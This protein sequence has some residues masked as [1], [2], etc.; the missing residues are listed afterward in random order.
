M[1]GGTDLT[2]D[3][4]WH[5]IFDGVRNGG[6]IFE[7]GMWVD[8]GTAGNTADDVLDTA[9][10]FLSTFLASS[11]TSSGTDVQ[12]T[13]SNDVHWTGITARQYHQA[14]ALPVL[15]FGTRRANSLVGEGGFSPLPLQVAVVGSWWNGRSVGRHR[16]NRSYWPGPSSSVITADGVLASN[17]CGDIVTALAAAN[18]AMLIST[19]ALFVC[20]YSRQTKEM[21][22][23]EQ[24]IV[25]NIPDTQRR[26]SRQLTRVKHTASL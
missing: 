2:G 23:L 1:P 3:D 4:L 18:A 9:V 14:T 21:L 8:A 6:E 5:V 25:D 12:H 20:Y 10:V 13:Y 19:P 17:Y 16:Y 7:T 11:A 22:S 15:P 26:R 24:A